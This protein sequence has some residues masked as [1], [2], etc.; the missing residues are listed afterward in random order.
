[1]FP[2]IADTLGPPLW[3][4]LEGISL[5]PGSIEQPE[6]AA[7]QRDP[8][9]RVSV[10]DTFARIFTRRPDRL[11]AAISSALAVPRSLAPA[12][13]PIVFRLRVAPFSPASD[14]SEHWPS[15]VIA[16]PA[17]VAPSWRLPS[18][19]LR[20]LPLPRYRP[21][22]Q[23]AQRGRWVWGMREYRGAHSTRLE[24]RD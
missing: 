4:R 11:P 15:C 5:L 12:M 6:E 17:A 8:R 13:A 24:W 18:L 19:L 22:A 7:R 21:V 1:M 2:K 23:R 16:P 10:P 9:A 14:P 3:T 20:P